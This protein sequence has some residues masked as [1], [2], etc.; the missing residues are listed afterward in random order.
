M[1]KTGRYLLSILPLL[2][3]FVIQIVAATIQMIRYLLLY[4]IEEGMLRYQGETD[5]VLMVVQFI[6]L[7][8]MGS[9]YY[10]AV[11]RKKQKLGIA[12]ESRF[13][14][15]AAGKLVLIGAG[16]YFLIS[17]LLV[18]WSLIAPGVIQEYAE[19]MEETG[20]GSFTVV[21]MITSVVLAPLS[22]ELT[23]RG[24]S[25]EYLKET[26][27]AF[28]KLNVLQALFF[29]IAHLNLVQGVYTFLIGLI[30]GYVAMKYR[31]LWASITLHAVI[32]A[33]GSCIPFLLEMIM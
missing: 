16:S 10:L 26:G 18:L 31:S 19:M 7:L 6:T 33:M 3:M 20:L 12:E 28:W 11:V 30:L 25:L 4:G 17:A 21:S 32:N 14:W 8:I 13:T 1:K 23:F 29:G 15:K 22:E 27:S 24:L 9:W 2:L 5:E